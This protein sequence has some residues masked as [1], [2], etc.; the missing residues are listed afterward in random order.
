MGTQDTKI[1]LTFPCIQVHLAGAN[2]VQNKVV[3]LAAP[4]AP[5]A[6]LGTG[7]DKAALKAAVRQKMATLAK[8]DGLHLQAPPSA[9]AQHISEHAVRGTNNTLVQKQ[10]LSLVPGWSG[11]DKIDK[12]EDDKDQAKKKKVKSQGLKVQLPSASFWQSG[13]PW[14]QLVAFTGWQ[15]G[16]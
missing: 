13:A 8:T 5:A 14:T 16:S 1:S 2:A 11:L 15:E 12:S 7:G 9:L 6:S 4:A 3:A 10:S